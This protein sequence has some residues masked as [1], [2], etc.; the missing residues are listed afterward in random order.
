MTELF[1]GKEDDANNFQ[2]FNQS[3]VLPDGVE[4]IYFGGCFNQPITFPH[5][6]T[7]IRFGRLFNQPVELPPKLELVDFGYHGT[8][9]HPLDL[10]QSLTSLYLSQKFNQPIT[11]PSPKLYSVAFNQ[12]F[13]QPVSL[14]GGVEM[15]SFSFSENSHS[16]CLPDSVKD[17]SLWSNCPISRMS[18]GLVELEVGPCYEHPIVFPPHLK[19]LIWNPDREVELP[20]GLRDVVFGDEFAHPIVLP[21][22]LKTVKF[23]GE[24]GLP[25]V[26][27]EGCVRYDKFDREQFDD[28]EIIQEAGK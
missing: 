18:Q 13:N 25:L 24:Y 2:H 8:F 23:E 11:L 16:L 27:P 19:K 4:R 26:L 17:L 9:N 7:T 21:P 5:S 10:P 1:F 22:G 3:L 15:V 28:E 12:D 6:V 20:A 14:P